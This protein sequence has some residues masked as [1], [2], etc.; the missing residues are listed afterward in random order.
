MPYL[1][2][3]D[4]SDDVQTF[5]EVFRAGG[6]LPRPLIDPF[7]SCSHLDDLEPA[8]E[9][10]RMMETIVLFP[11]GI[12]DSTFFMEQIKCAD[13]RS[14][15]NLVTLGRFEF[16][17]VLVCDMR[18]C[19]EIQWSNADGRYSGRTRASHNEKWDYWC[20]AAEIIVVVDF[21][22]VKKFHLLCTNGK[23]FLSFH[24]FLE[25]GEFV[26]MGN[27]LYPSGWGDCGTSSCCSISRKAFKLSLRWGSVPWTRV[28]ST[29]PLPPFY[30]T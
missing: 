2:S 23:G 24:P 27:V 9:L 29:P 10:N 7:T 30:R 18:A 5:Y 16:P 12:V 28:C 13:L 17:L 8:E 14:R 1:K 22:E 21:L 4:E 19:T 6:P 25:R 11:G 3:V 20:V 15:Y 26:N